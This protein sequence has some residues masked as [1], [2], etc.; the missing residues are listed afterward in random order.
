MLNIDLH[1]HS[2]ASDG[3]LSPANLAIRA[4]Y[5]GVNIFALTDHDEISGIKLAHST[6]LDLGMHCIPGVEISVTWSRRTIHIVGLQIDIKNTKLIQ[7]LASIRQS[8]QRRAKKIAKQLEKVGIPSAFSGALKYVS[9]PNLISR[10]H[11]ARYLVEI[12][13]CINIKEVFQRYLGSDK[14]CNVSHRWINLKEAINLI[15]DAGGVAVIAHPGR[16]K[17]SALEFNTLFDEFKQYGG[18]GIEVT[19]GS[20][21]INQYKKYAEIAKHFGFLA[22]TGSDFHDPIESSVDI[23]MITSLPLGLKPIWHNW[24]KCS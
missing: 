17:Y 13:H 22:S 18:I 11:F 9:N 7:G 6:A 24:Y 5:N 21:K 20:H 12:G 10:I 2:N 15:H 8:R 19:T 3:L 14:L 16:Y 23:G 4:K 1:C